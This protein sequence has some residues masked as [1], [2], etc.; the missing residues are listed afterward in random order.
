[1]NSARLTRVLIICLMCCPFIFCGASLVITLVLLILWFAEGGFLT[2]IDFLKSHRFLLFLPL[3]YVLFMFGLLYSSNVS[4]GIQKAET[5]L[6]LL[7]LPIVLPTLKHA[8][9][10]IHG[11][12]YFIWYIRI[13]AL[14]SLVCIG[15]GF[16]HYFQEVNAINSGE[17][18]LNPVGHNYFLSSHLTGF[19]MHPGYYAVYVVLA[20]FALFNLMLYKAKKYLRWNWLFIM[21]ILVSLL[22]LS[23]AKTA[24][25][26]FVLLS[27]IFGMQ[28]AYYK[29]KMIYLL[30]GFIIATTS[31][32]VF[33][34]F[35]PNT[36][37]RVQ[38]IQDV[39]ITEKLDP[40]STESTQARAH[41]WRGALAALKKSPIYGFGTGDAN[42]E[43]FKSYEELNYTGVLSREFN[44]HNEYLQ[45]ALALG[46][47][48]VFFL[49]LPFIL[50]FRLA[51]IQRSFYMGS[52]V[53]LTCIVFLFESYL[54]MQAGA[55]FVGLFFSILPFV[56]FD[57][58]EAINHQK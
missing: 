30:Y 38:A 4:F 19:I 5:R 1:M 39:I 13:A 46:L 55:L 27:L 14:S 10:H 48:G 26:V 33:Y 35:V 49:V 15:Q 6:A 56:R 47:V 36:Q 25:I 18:I 23:Y 58:F 8:D 20:I 16:F 42:D 51:W 37:E 28:T 52:W 45:T 22:F 50:L 54:N 57:K 43:L 40:T 44:A 34:F 9:W 32:L 12:R 31:L 29:N 3:L 17:I 53:L 21:I 11:E 7:I 41:T 2:K 24:L